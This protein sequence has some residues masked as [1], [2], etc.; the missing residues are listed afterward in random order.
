MKNKTPEGTAELII[1]LLDELKIDSVK[2]IGISAGG[3]TALVLAANYPERVN[4]LVL[5]S[6]ITKKWLNPTDEVYKKGKKLFS[7]KIEKFTWLIYKFSFTIFPKIMTKVT[8]KELSKYRPVEFSNKEMNELKDMTM[9]MRSYNGFDNDLDQNINQD[10]LRKIKC[11]T[12]I[13]HSKFDNAVAFEHP[14]NAKMN[15]KNSELIVFENNW[16]H[17]LWLGDNFIKPFTEIQK[18]WNE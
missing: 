1:S 9:K 14:E 15:I 16:G 5:I 18:R 17:L 2:V 13:L 7:P 6:A 8:F 12:L 11:K 4:S 3:L 10:I